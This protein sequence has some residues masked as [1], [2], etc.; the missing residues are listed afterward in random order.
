[1]EKQRRRKRRDK[2]G[3]QEGIEEMKGIHKE[4]K[5]NNDKVERENALLVSS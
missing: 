1:M 2:E 3:P 4:R 5:G